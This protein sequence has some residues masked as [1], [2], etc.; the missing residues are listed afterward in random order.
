MSLAGRAAFGRLWR[1]GSAAVLEPNGGVRLIERPTSNMHPPEGSPSGLALRA[2][3]IGR[4]TVLDRLRSRQAFAR[5]A[6][7]C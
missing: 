7:I 2:R 4:E 6:F 1:P 5:R 3:L